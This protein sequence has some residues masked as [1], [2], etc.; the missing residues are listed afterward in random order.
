[1]Y[2]T[3]GSGVWWDPGPRRVVA[4][5]LVDALLKFK[6]LKEIVDHLKWVE[7][8]DRRVARFRAWVQWRVAFGSTPW[9]TVLAGAAAGNET[10]AAFASAGELLGMLLTESPPEGV[11]S[12]VLYEQVHFWPRGPQWA[13]P[14]HE[15]APTMVSPCVRG[16]GRVTHHRQD[17]LLRRMTGTGIGRVHFAPEMV[18]FRSTRSNKKGRHGTAWRAAK[19]VPKGMWDYFSADE[20]GT[21]A[22]LRSAS[23]G[24]CT[25]CAG[26]VAQRL[27]ECALFRR[28]LGQPK[29]FSALSL[30]TH[31]AFNARSA[32]ECCRSFSS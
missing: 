16:A 4:R 2:H 8:G 5:N 23:S 31:P 6:T 29:R 9:E 27:C 24:V 13:I 19:E 26:G 30:L 21:T 25:S 1:M 3:P 10:F 12:I 15:F 20:A 22:C 17:P 14:D 18:E 11:D 7:L 28:G 32:Y